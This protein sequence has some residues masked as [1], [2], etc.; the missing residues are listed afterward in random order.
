MI[1]ELAALGASLVWAIGGLMLKPLSNR[2]Q[3]LLLN[4]IRCGSA[5]VIFGVLFLVNGKSASFSTVPVSSAIVAIL[6]TFLGIGIGESLFVVSLRYLDISRAY[7]LS[8]CA[9][10][11]LTILISVSFFGDTISAIALAGIVI[12]LLGIYFL[13]YPTGPLFTGL[14]LKTPQEKRGMFLLL[15]AVIAWGISTVAVREGTRDIDSTTAN[16]LRMAGTAVILAPFTFWKFKG[17]IVQKL[18]WPNFGLASLNGVISFG[19]GGIMYL[20]ALKETGASLTSV[21]TSTSPV[22][23]LPMSVF[24]LKEKVT[25]KL[26]LGAVLSVLG[27]CLTLLPG[28][29]G[30]EVH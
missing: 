22:F 8:V 3:P 13:T 5:A 6:G 21:L 2:F 27:I 20:L 14:S 19:L 25:V 18:S 29:I 1:G 11:I 24:F 12:V 16:F 17:D 15:L 23:L 26:I 9:Y 28:I 7:P 30:A 4:T 10:P